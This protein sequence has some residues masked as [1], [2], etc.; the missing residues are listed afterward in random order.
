MH[1]QT[2]QPHIPSASTDRKQR[3]PHYAQAQTGCTMR[4]TMRTHRQDAAFATQCKH[5]YASQP[6]TTLR[7]VCAASRTCTQS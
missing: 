1:V 2:K 4:H 3:A 6:L 5:S 7:G